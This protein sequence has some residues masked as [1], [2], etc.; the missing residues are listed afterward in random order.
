M[1]NSGQSDFQ[2]IGE[3]VEVSYVADPTIGH[4][5]FRLENHGQNQAHALVVSVWLHLG[6][7][8]EEL[9]SF[10]AYD[11]DQEQAIDPQNITIAANA[12]LR[13]LVGFPAIVYEPAFGES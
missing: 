5:E 3:T 11:L 2:L 8:R 7:R 12:T 6:D 1:A 9:D 4:G 10:T 13:F